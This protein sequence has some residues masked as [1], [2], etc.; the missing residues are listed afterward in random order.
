MAGSV[1]GLRANEEGAA[2]E[3]AREERAHALDEKKAAEGLA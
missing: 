1:K 3:E 2:E